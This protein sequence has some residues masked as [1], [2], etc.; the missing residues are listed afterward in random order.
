MRAAWF[1]AWNVSSQ[2]EYSFSSLG[3]PSGALAN[4]S[5]MVCHAYKCASV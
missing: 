1:L 2:R 5:Q 4:S 3:S